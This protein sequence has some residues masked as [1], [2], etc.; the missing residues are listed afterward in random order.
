FLLL[1]FTLPSTTE[2]YP[3]SLHDA[4]PILRQFPGNPR[5]VGLHLHRF[6]EHFGGALEIAEL[7][8]L[9]G[10]YDQGPFA[11]RLF[12]NGFQ[13]FD[14]SRSEEHTSELQSLTISYAVF[15]LK[16]KTY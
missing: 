11:G 12:G 8:V 3:L 10:Q 6:L 13:L 9:I 5:V 1:S 14:G 15:C 16:K 4:L 7:L 2:S